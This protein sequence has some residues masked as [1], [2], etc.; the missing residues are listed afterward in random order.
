MKFKYS[1]IGNNTKENI[2]WLRSIGWRLKYEQEEA[3]VIVCASNTGMFSIINEETQDWFAEYSTECLNCRSNP[4]LFQA[5]TAISTTTDI[6]KHYINNHTG[7]WKRCDYNMATDENID[8]NDWSEATLE[9]LQ[10]YFK[11]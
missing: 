6:G 7:Q 3:N 9:E 8:W 1:V 11:I 5:V 2:E 10:D 4:P